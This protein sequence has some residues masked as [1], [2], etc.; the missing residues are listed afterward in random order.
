MGGDAKKVTRHGLLPSQMT[1]NCGESGRDTRVRKYLSVILGLRELLEEFKCS[2]KRK[3]REKEKGR[4]IKHIQ[5]C[6]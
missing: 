6:G 2:A 4:E 5:A 1:T 3:E